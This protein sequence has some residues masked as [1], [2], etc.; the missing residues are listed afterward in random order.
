MDSHD[1]PLIAGTNITL[2]RGD[3]GLTISTTNT[4]VAA[5]TAAMGTGSIA[6]AACATVVTVSATGVL[7]TDVIQF[8]LNGDITGVTGYIP[9]T[10]GTLYI[11][12][13]PTANNVNFKACNNTSGAI[14]PGA[15]TLNWRV[16]R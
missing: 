8:G 16:A 4:T 11:Y 15:V 7:T 13:Y 9:S 3:Y 12:A 6:S 2:A 10:A 5:G 14:V 1:P